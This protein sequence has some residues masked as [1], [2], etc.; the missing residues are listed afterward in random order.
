MYD[1]RAKREE[2]A[3]TSNETNDEMPKL[4]LE[5]PCRWRYKI[6]GTH[7]ESMVEAVCEVIADKEHTLTHSNSSKS[8]KYTS[9]NLDMLVHNEDERTF[10]YEA[11]KAHKNI[12][13]V[14]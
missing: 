7:K 8:G 1:S 14:L 3:V 9:L 11:L 4:E 6:V 5:Y 13:M 12:K 10:I 2:R